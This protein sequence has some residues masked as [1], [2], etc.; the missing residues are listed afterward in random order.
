MSIGTDQIGPIVS[1]R[2]KKAALRQTAI[3][4]RFVT[5]STGIRQTS[6]P[7]MLRMM[8]FR[9]ALARSPVLWSTRSL[10][11]PPSVSPMTP[12]KNTPNE[13]SAEFLI[14]SP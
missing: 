6:E 7:I 2:K 10:M 4:T 14:L 3:S 8:V 13:K 11:T 12:E 9:R 1:S 5:N